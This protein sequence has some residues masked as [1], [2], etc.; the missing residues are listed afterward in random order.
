MRI[1]AYNQISQIYSANRAS[2]VSSPAKVS[3]AKDEFRLS[4][5]G[6][7]MQIA[8]QAVAEASDIREDKVASIK[9]RMAAGNYDVDTGD[10]ASML[11]SKFNA[12]I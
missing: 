11:M 1:D 2:K 3:G 6:R 10:F 9:Q 4:S 8:K 12:G 7:D 5:K